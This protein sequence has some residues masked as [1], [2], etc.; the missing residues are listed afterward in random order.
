MITYTLA[1]L[2]WIALII[3]RNLS[4]AASLGSVVPVFFVLKYLFLYLRE[5]S[6]FLEPSR[7]SLEKPETLGI[8]MTL[9]FWA[10]I[11]LGL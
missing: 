11:L 1:L 6:R 9:I 4:L 5:T 3:G 2:T 10:Y 8:A 7:F